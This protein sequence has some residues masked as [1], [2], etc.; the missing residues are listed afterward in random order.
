MMK[1]K[2]K[3]SEEIER[4]R[5]DENEKKKIKKS[6]YS[7]TWVLPYIHPHP[8][9]GRAMHATHLSLATIFPSQ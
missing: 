8:L 9:N 2:T 3:R 7:T 5:D 6:E 4:D 1:K